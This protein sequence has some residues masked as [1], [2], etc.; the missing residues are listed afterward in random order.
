M[1]CKKIKS[2][3]SKKEINRLRD[4]LNRELQKPS[5]QKYYARLMMYIDD[6]EQIAFHEYYL[7]ILFFIKYYRKKI[8]ISIK[9]KLLDEYKNRT[10]DLDKFRKEI[11]Q[12]HYKYKQKDWKLFLAKSEY[13]FSLHKDAFDFT[14][15]PNEAYLNRIHLGMG[16]EFLLKSIFL[17]KGYLIN[18]YETIIYNNSGKLKTK[19]KNEQN[20]IKRLNKYNLI[21]SSTKNNITV[22]KITLKK[23]IKI[24]VLSKKFI[25]REVN[26]LGYFINNLKEIKPSKIESKDFNY[27]ILAGLLIAQS[28]RNQEMHIP[29]SL[30]NTDNKIERYLKYSHDSLYKK[31]LPKIKVPQF[32]NIK[33]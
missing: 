18:K 27:Y 8:D 13:F 12:K 28:W 9:K 23:P 33:P 25:K 20:T 14:Q 3:L 30:R 26:E 10:F 7:S 15:H 5:N 21:D 29:I 11:R 19:F 17:K 24:G 32:P 2:I 1:Q 16:F 22:K 4:I 31:L 6:L